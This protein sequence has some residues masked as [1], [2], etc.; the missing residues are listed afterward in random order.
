MTKYH[1]FFDPHPLIRSLFKMYVVYGVVVCLSSYLSL[2][3]RFL[4]AIYFVCL[5][6]LFYF[7]SLS[8]S[9]F[10]FRFVNRYGICE[11]IHVCFFVFSQPLGGFLHC[12]LYRRLF[13]CG[14]IVCHRQ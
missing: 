10:P 1:N 3:E 13:V 5:C 12:G 8:S 6:V 9:L 11:L 14:E 7:A 4:A 2:F